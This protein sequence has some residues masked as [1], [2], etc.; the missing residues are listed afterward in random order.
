MQWWEEALRT[1]SCVTLPVSVTAVM[2]LERNDTKLSLS[3]DKCVV[4]H[5]SGR[6]QVPLAGGTVSHQRGGVPQAT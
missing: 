4:M 2:E 5:A 1:A 3:Q 6:W